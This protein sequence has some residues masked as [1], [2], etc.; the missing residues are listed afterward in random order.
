M[1]RI[2]LAPL[3]MLPLSWGCCLSPFAVLSGLCGCGLL[4]SLFGLPIPPAGWLCMIYDSLDLM[5]QNLDVCPW[6]CDWTSAG[7]LATSLL[8]VSLPLSLAPSRC[9]EQQK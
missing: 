8:P 7:S 4:T 1:Y 9:G 2:C 6:C 3:Q 5:V